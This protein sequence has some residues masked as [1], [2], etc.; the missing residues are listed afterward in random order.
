M[1]LSFLEQ[2]KTVTEITLH[3]FEPNHG[4]NEGDAVHSCVERM[5][6][7]VTE[8]ITPNELSMIIRMS[9]K[10]N[11]RLVNIDTSDILNWKQVSS[12][13]GII[14]CRTAENGT[15]IDW[16]KV[17]QIHVEKEKPK[18]VGFKMSHASEDWSWLNIG[19]RRLARQRVHHVE[20]AF[21]QTSVLSTEKSKDLRAL[22]SGQT[23][24]ISNTEHRL[25]YRSIM[26]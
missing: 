24:V 8:V 4:Q 2:S 26:H 23:P 12:D 16:T 15:A 11:N 22:M 18:K 9:R 1:L 10:N 13:Y 19:E 14:R 3:S 21:Q 25:F 5:L 6:P 17:R 7:R 20:Q